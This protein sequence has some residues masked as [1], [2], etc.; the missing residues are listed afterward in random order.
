MISAPD[1]DRLRKVAKRTN[2]GNAQRRNGAIM[3]P[4][5][6]AVNGEPA[7]PKAKRPR[8]RRLFVEPSP[9]PWRVD[10]LLIL[11]A[12]G[13]PVMAAAT[14]SPATL[15]VLEANAALVAACVNKEGDRG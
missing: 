14:G 11:D 8:Q 13:R 7:K 2:G 10:G 12:T 9:R 1:G 4:T 3:R 6:P 15:E 5:Q